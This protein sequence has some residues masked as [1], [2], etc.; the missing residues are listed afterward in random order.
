[1]TIHVSIA[2]YMKNN[3]CR[4]TCTIR[5]LLFVSLNTIVPFYFKG[6]VLLQITLY[7]NYRSLHSV[8]IIEAVSADISGHQEVYTDLCGRFH[9]VLEIMKG[10]EREETEEKLDNLVTRRTGLQVHVHVNVF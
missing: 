10:G 3:M 5:E 7:V 1:M 8:F 2:F 9:T 4:C 6:G